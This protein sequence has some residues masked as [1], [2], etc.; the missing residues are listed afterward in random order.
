MSPIVSSTG[1]EKKDLGQ[2]VMGA[3]SDICTSTQN[4]V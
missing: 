2:R 3:V 4:T 1:N